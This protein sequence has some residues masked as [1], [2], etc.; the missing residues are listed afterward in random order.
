MERFEQELRV[1]RCGDD[2]HGSGAT[3]MDVDAL[4]KVKGGEKVGKGK[5]KE[6]ETKKFD[7]HCYRCGASGHVVKDCRKKAAC[8]AKSKGKGKGFRRTDVRNPVR[9]LQVC[10]WLLT[11]VKSMADL[12][13]TTS[14]RSAASVTGKP[15]C[16][17]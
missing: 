10:S 17:S 9:K 7:G 3:P 1:E 5:D 2:V 14:V 15:G 12:K 6:S 8:K 16:E 11:D 4:V 13:S